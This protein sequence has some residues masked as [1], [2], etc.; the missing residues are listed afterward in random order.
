LKGF[1]VADVCELGG[2]RDKEEV[3]EASFVESQE[4]V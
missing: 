1:Y 3:T 4:L 2:Q